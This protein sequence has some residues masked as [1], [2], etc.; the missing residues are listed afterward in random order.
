M[1]GEALRVCTV[2]TLGESCV[3]MSFS[4]GG[5]GGRETVS[6]YGRRC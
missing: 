2:C 5:M 1:R 4:N 3:G 6:M